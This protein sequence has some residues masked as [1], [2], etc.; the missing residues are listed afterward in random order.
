MATETKSAAMP[1]VQRMEWKAKQDVMKE[2][3]KFDGVV[4][5]GA[6]RDWLIHNHYASKFYEAIAE[7]DGERAE[8]LE[9]YSDPMFLPEFKGRNISPN[10]I[11]A[12]LPRSRVSDFLEALKKKHYTVTKHFSRD[13]KMYFPRMTIGLGQVFHERYTVRMI[14]TCLIGKVTAL[15]PTAVSFEPAFYTQLE[16]IVETLTHAMGDAPV[17][18]TIDLM[19]SQNDVFYEPPF[20]NIDFECNGLLLDNAGIRLTKAMNQKWSCP[21][22]YDRVYTRIKD[23]ILNFQAHIS[24]TFDALQEYRIRKMVEKGW[25]ITNFNTVQYHHDPNYE[26]HCLVC[27]DELPGNHYKMKCCDAR[28]HTRC[29]LRAMKDGIAAMSSTKACLMCKKKNTRTNFALDTAIL[30]HIAPEPV[31]PDNLWD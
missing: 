21:L 10:D 8:L 30:S 20:G 13:A 23:D 24:G 22:E 6:V 17:S 9:K 31:A 19:V 28:Y 11:D 1:N 14:P 7:M 15:F 16:A 18:F 12:T 26:G 4:F 3:L 29:L 5:G 2:L 25:T 27:H